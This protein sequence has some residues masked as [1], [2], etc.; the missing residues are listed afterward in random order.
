MQQVLVCHRVNIVEAPTHV[1][2]ILVG[3]VAERKIEKSDNC[4]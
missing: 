4:K 2:D 1:K 3:G